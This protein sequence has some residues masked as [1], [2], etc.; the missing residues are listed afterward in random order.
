MRG[1]PPVVSVVIE[2]VFRRAAAH[3]VSSCCE[4]PRRNRR[5]GSQVRIVGRSH[6]D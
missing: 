4:T 6:A 1:R 3:R 5:A 2:Q